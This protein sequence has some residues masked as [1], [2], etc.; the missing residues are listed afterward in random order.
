MRLTKPIAGLALVPGAAL[1]IRKLGS[2]RVPGAS[3]EVTAVKLVYMRAGRWAA[4]RALLGR[5]VDRDHPTKGR[6][7]CEQVE[8]VLART[9]EG[10]DRLAPGAHVERLQ[11]RGARQNALL[12]VF[13]LAVYRALLAEGIEASYATELVGDLA[14]TIYQKWIVLPRLLARRA[15]D[16]PQNQMNL[17][18]RMFLRFP[19]NRPGYDWKAST[20]DSGAY[21]IDFYRCPMRDYLRSQGEEEFMLGSICALDFALAQAMVEGGRYERTHTLSAGDGICDMKWRADRLQ[22][23]RHR[24]AGAPPAAKRDDTVASTSDH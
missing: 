2:E 8:A 23:R 19:F 9:W 16:D 18:L 10:Y 1:I 11:T 20:D 24:R 17:M 13:A 3:A 21:A 22:A 15:T 4:K 7:T 12:A 5:Y 14:W 6:L